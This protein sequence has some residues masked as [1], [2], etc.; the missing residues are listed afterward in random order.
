M[1]DDVR[2]LKLPLRLE[3]GFLMINFSK[4]TLAGGGALGICLI[5]VAS[6]G[7]AAKTKP[8]ARPRGRSATAAKVSKIVAVSLGAEPQDVNAK[9]GVLQ[10]RATQSASKVVS[11]TNR[12]KRS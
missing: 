6:L 5:M 8:V 10:K 4:K 7:L 9:L 2:P 3:S 1:A 12:K 11:V